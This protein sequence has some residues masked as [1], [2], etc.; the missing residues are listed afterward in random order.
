M[1]NNVS[2]SD[3]ENPKKDATIV[4]LSVALATLQVRPQE[5]TVV[6]KPSPVL[7]KK[8]LAAP[9]LK[10]QKRVAAVAASLEVHQPSASSDNV[11]IVVR[12]RLYLFLSS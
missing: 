9:P 7:P 2:S 5:E 11:S 8:N 4:P 10:R 1:S 6:A 3:D 12:T